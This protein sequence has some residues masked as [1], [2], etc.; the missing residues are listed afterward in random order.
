MTYFKLLCFYLFIYLFCGWV[1]CGGG[2]GDTDVNT[3]SSSL[4]D[5]NPPHLL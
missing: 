2:G 3:I 1:E 5:I 4:M